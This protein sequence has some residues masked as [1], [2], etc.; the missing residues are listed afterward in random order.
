MLFSLSAYFIFVISTNYNVDSMRARGHIHLHQHSEI[1]TQF[2]QCQGL[3][4]GIGTQH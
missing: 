1:F 3:F 2:I 4:P